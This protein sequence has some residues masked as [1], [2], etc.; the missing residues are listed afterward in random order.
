M[1]FNM[2]YS[3]TIVDLFEH[4]DVI[5]IYQTFQQTSKISNRALS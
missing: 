4:P 2:I 3:H 1:T 5:L